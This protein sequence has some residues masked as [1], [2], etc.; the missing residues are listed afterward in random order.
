M[1]QQSGTAR[2]VNN[3]HCL[4]CWYQHATSV[5]D[6]PEHAGTTCYFS[7]GQCIANWY[8]RAMSE[9]DIAQQAAE[10]WQ[11]KR[12]LSA[13]ACKQ[14]NPRQRWTMPSEHT[15]TRPPGSWQ[16]QCAAR[17]IAELC[18]PTNAQSS[19]PDVQVGVVACLDA[20]ELE[21]GGTS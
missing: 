14:P 7:T 20:G 19:F 3:G 1:A 13:L 12:G 4:A 11:T 6:M 18:T 10:T 21:G 2:N 16:A 15:P 8:Q 5:L 17:L 9:P